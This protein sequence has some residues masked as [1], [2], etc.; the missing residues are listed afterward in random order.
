MLTSCVLH[1]VDEE[2]ESLLYGHSER[3]AIAFGLLNTP[4]GAAIRV[5]KNLGF[6]TIATLQQNSSPRLLIGRLLQ[7]VLM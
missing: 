6:A 1:N 4:H 5:L 7:A 2:K 3:L